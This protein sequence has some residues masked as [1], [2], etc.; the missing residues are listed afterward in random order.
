MQQQRVVAERRVDDVVL[1]D[2]RGG[3]ALRVVAD[4]EAALGGRAGRA[5]GV[6]RRADLPAG[7]Q[8]AEAAREVVVRRV[9]EV[10]PLVQAVLAPELDVAVVVGVRDDAV[11]ADLAPG[12]GVARELGLRGDRVLRLVDVVAV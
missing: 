1:G 12:V 11:V 8:P 7:V 9:V 6:Q 3:R 5:V 2:V 10:H 4:A